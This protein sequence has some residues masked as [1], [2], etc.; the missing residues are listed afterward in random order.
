MEI[1]NPSAKTEREL[2]IFRDS[3]TSSLA[4]LL[5]ES[6]KTITLVDLRYINSSILDKYINFENQDVLFIYNSLILNQNVLK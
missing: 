5:V 6:Y 2:V 1:N 3:F 4:P